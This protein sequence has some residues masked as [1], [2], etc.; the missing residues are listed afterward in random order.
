V[1]QQ[2]ANT[3]LQAWCANINWNITRAVVF[4]DPY[5]M[6]V[7]WKTIEA[8]AETK[9]I[10][11]WIL[12]PLGQ[13]VNRLLTRRSFPQG[14][15]ANH[16]TTFFGTDEWKDSFYSEPRQLTMF[17]PNNKFE[18]TANFDSIGEFFIKRLESVFP[19][20]AKTLSR[21]IILEEFLFTFYVLLQ[22]I[23]EGLQLLSE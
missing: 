1:I 12:F 17:G 21:F 9:G 8:I 4:L 6:Q 22:L 14:A 19:K 7:E 3:F 10:D 2:E 15:W 20:V 23:P 18:K 16:L 5:G 11:L 13:A